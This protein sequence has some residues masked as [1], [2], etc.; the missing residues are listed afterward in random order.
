MKKVIF[1][2]IVAFITATVIV[3]NLN[4]FHRIKSKVISV[5]TDSDEIKNKNKTEGAVWG[6]DISHHQ[7]KIDWDVLVKEN[8]PSFVFLKATE[9]TT[10]TDQYFAERYKKLKSLGIPTGAYHFFTY[11][12]VGET[13]AANFINT[14]TLNK[15]DLIPSLDLE[16][17]NTKLQ[18]TEWIIKEIKSFCTEIKSKFGFYPMIYCENDFVVKYLK[19]PFFNDFKYWI[20]D[21]YREPKSDYVFWQYKVGYIKGIGRVDVDVLKKGLKLSDYQ[22][23]L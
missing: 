23:P 10:D 5:L 16:F 18:S 7:S 14:I 4:A 11:R 8:K 13:Q 15:G 9:G 3:L 2:S 12:T 21:F 6:I 1:I 19:D 22:V 20:S 17:T